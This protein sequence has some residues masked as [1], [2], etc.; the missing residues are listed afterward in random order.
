MHSMR[1]GLPNN[2]ST[3][4]YALTLL[5]LWLFMRR[6]QGFDGD[7][8]LYA[9]QALSRIYHGLSAD[10]YL[11]NNSQDRYTLFSPFYAW[12]ISLISTRGCSSPA[13]FIFHNLVCC[14]L[15][16]LSRGYYQPQRGLVGNRFFR[17][18]KW[19]LR[20]QRC[21]PHFRTVL[22]CTPSGRGT[23]HYGSC[24]LCSRSETLG[25]V[26][27]DRGSGGSSPDGAPGSSVVDLRMASYSHMPHHGKQRDSSYAHRRNIGD[28]STCDCSM[29]RHGRRLARG[30]P[31]AIARFLFLQLWSLRGWGNQSATARLFGDFI[32]VASENP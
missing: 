3:L 30:C 18:N 19:R 4:T 24:C 15:L 8:Q 20:R 32:A 11:Q 9:F 6:Y 17:R 12:F 28:N 22:D 13:D 10:L 5:A 1:N 7:A 29:G 16:E 31:G 14:R 25:P 21:I 27:C 26:N 2:L 23:D